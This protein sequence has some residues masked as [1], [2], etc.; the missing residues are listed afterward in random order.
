[1]AERCVCLP[2]VVKPVVNGVGLQ[3]IL[4]QIRKTICHEEP[5]KTSIPPSMA[6]AKSDCGSKQI[7]AFLG[8]L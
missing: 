3:Q 1:M 6:N 2:F 5:R 4:Q 7:V 8:G